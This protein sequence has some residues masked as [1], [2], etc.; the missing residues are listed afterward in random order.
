MVT[1]GPP[2]RPPY[3]AAIAVRMNWLIKAARWGL[4]CAKTL[5]HNARQ[6][7]ILL[8]AVSA[9]QVDRFQ[10]RRRA[11]RYGKS[12]P[13]APAAISM[14]TLR[15]SLFSLPLAGAD[16]D[17]GVSANPSNLASALC[18]DGSTPSKLECQ[19]ERPSMGLCALA[20]YLRRRTCAG[21]KRYRRAGRCRD[22]R[23]P[24]PGSQRPH[25]ERGADSRRRDNAD[26][27]LA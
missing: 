16:C 18:C 17:C 14:R 7:W 2:F 9:L 13:V 25:C 5:D 24:E 4:A 6:H 15:P 12:S 23:S 3:P 26:R 19:D 21:G 8:H 1:R 22:W 10:K 20:S 11:E 27:E